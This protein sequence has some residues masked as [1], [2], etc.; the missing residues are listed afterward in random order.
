MTILPKNN[1]RGQEHP[2]CLP[3]APALAGILNLTEDSFSDGGK[4]F[5]LQDALS[6]GEKLLREGAFLLDVGAESTRPGAEEIPPEKELEKLLPFLAAFREKHPG[7]IISIDTR[8]SM[9]AEKALLAGADIINDV[10]GLRF[11]P[12]MKEV[13][14][15]YGCPLILMHSRGTP[16]DMQDSRNLDY[17]KDFLA[18]FCEEVE[19]MIQK[20]LSS[21]IAREKI[22]LDPGLG[23]AKTPEQNWELI[24]QCRFLRKRFAL[25]LFYGCSRKSFLSLPSGSTLSLEERESVH[26]AILGFL[27]DEGADFFRVHDVKSAGNFLAARRILCRGGNLPG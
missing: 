11:D 22:I 14:A 1:R 17:G 8:K 3:P 18:A 23:F 4:Y 21:G 20:A 16:K 13:A 15:R 27:G 10:S 2:F 5:H 25:P 7:A 12:A 9:V 24:R 19:A 6:Q 26:L